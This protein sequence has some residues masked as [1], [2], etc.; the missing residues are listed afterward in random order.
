MSIYTGRV[1]SLMNTGIMLDFS[2][3]IALLD[4]FDTPLLN[5]IGGDGSPSIGRG[6]AATEIKVEWQDETLLTPRC[7]MA[8]T[9]VTADTNI[10]L[11]SNDIYR[12]MSDDVIRIDSELILVTGYSAT[13]AD[14]LTITRAFGG[15]TAAQHGYSAGSPK[16]VVGVGTATI[17][18]SAPQPARTVDRTARYNLTQIIGPYQVSVTGTTQAIRK[19]GVTSEYDHQVGKVVK[20]MG[21]AIEQALVYGTR[22]AGTQ[23]VTG[24]PY[25]TLGGL[26]YW[27]TTNVNTS[28]TFTESTLLDTLQTCFDQGGSPDRI[29]LGSANK[30][31]ASAFTSS[32]SIQVMRP[33][34]Q[35]GV[36]VDQFISDFGAAA[37]LLDRW[38][39]KSDVFIFE[40]GQA[41]TRYLRP[42]QL[43]ML[44]ITGDSIN[45]MMLCEMTLQFERQRHAAKFNAIT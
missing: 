27:I 14:T 8:S 22:Y 42:A 25:R 13:T 32:G 1:P 5:G 19:Y 21:V 37:L 30:R 34:T 18:G 7:L 3:A 12:F 36:V 44:G 17:E 6:P 24:T 43:Q 35:R 16:P 11:P 40:G 10:T 23:A 15:S 20:A 28:T 45:S 39:R 26:D 41:T 29:V 38:V 33:D 9:V 4:P 2:P 31:T